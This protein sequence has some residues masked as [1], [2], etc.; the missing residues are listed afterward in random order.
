MVLA[1]SKWP[2]GRHDGQAF[3]VRFLQMVTFFNNSKHVLLLLLQQSSC[4]K[5]LREQG[6]VP[7]RTSA[8]KGR[9]H[10]LQEPGNQRTRNTSCCGRSLPYWTS[11]ETRHCFIVS[12]R[13]AKLTRRPRRAQSTLTSRELIRTRRGRGGHGQKVADSLRDERL[14]DGDVPTTCSS[15][16]AENT[17]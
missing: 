3:R 16:P 5:G 4:R 7:L 14:G 10:H 12:F 6:G 9:L 15:F 17:W 1:P 13:W 2:S 11:P 8:R